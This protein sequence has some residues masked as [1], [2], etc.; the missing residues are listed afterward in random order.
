MRVNIIIAKRDRNEHLKVCLHYLNRCCS[1]SK[2]KVNVYVVDDSVI[3]F[4]HTPYSNFNLV[5]L[6]YPNSGLFNKSKLINYALARMDDFDWFSL[7]D[8]DMI[9]SDSFLSSIHKKVTLNYEYIVSHGYKLGETISKYTTTNLPELEYVT[10]TAEKYEFKVGPSQITMT[11]RAYQRFL[12]VFG[13][14]LYDEFYEGWG[15]EDSDISSKSILLCRRHMLLKDE[16]YNM[17]Y[18]IY[19]EGSLINQQQYQKNCAHL[20]ERY[21]KNYSTITQ[22][23]GGGSHAKTHPNYW[24]H[25][26]RR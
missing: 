3:S 23:Y 13:T 8:I 18:H 21:N 9:Y 1:D 7:V 17:W 24:N 10:S 15:A 16:I 20:R 22:K 5:Y 6:S 11:K 12:D 4:E 19:H 2:Y 25:G 26:S 14:P